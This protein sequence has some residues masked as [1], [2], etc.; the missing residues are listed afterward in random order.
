M[1]IQGMPSQALA[2][3]AGMPG[4]PGMGGQINPQMLMEL[5]QV[6]QQM[7]PEQ[8]AALLAAGAPLSSDTLDGGT[9]RHGLPRG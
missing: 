9:P 8:R 6:V 1:T 2:G 4:M 3:M 7:P 5:M